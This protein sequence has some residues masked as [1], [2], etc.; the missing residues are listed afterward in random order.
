MSGLDPARESPP[1]AT[2][3]NPN[4][5]AVCLMIDEK[6]EIIKLTDALHWIEDGEH[7][8]SSTEF[9]VASSGASFS[10]AFL[11]MMDNLIQEARSLGKLIEDANAAQNEREEALTLFT[12]LQE[13]V[14]AEEKAQR[15]QEEAAQSHTRRRRRRDSAG[16]YTIRSRRWQTQH[17]T[18][19][20]SVHAL[21]A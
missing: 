19:R 12:R 13:L 18:Q 7:I 11:Q 5:G 6:G 10:D 20:R 3:D 4:E 17:R 15:R 16:S 21:P 1:E 8:I 2:A 14:E 9:Q